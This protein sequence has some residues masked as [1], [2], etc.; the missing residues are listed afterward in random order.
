MRLILRHFHQ[1]VGFG[2]NPPF[3]CCRE[4][5]KLTR[6]AAAKLVSGN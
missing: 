2:I 6:M 4:L 5:N 1:S 3:L